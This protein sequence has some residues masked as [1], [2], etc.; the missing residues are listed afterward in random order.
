M[1]R[2]TEV[3]ELRIERQEEI[4][5]GHFLNTPLDLVTMTKEGSEASSVEYH[6][7]SSKGKTREAEVARTPLSTVPESPPPKNIHKESKVSF[8]AQVYA[9]FVTPTGYHLPFR[10]NR[11]EPPARYSPDIEEKDQNTWSQDVTIHGLPE[12]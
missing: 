9:H 10:Y 11:G 12:S 8:P 1:G 4:N 6:Q 3:V 5:I 2:R 7:E